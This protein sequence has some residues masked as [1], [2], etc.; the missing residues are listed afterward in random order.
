MKLMG[1]CADLILVVNNKERHRGNNMGNK[2]KNE[3]VEIIRNYE[4]EKICNL[5]KLI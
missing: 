1:V 4:F 2:N 3:E 5:N